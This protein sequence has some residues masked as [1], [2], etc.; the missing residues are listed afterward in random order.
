MSYVPEFVALYE[1]IPFIEYLVLDTES[2]R[3]AVKYY[4]EGGETRNF[5]IKIYGKIEDWNTSEVTDM[6]GLFCQYYTFNEDI[7][8]WNTSKVTNMSGMFYRAMSFNKPIGGW[9]TSKVTDMRQRGLYFLARPP[10]SSAQMKHPPCGVAAPSAVRRPS[11]S[12]AVS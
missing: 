12:L 6:S 7:S 9:D 11:F 2:I 1:I 5:I 3:F 8:K 4:L 10:P